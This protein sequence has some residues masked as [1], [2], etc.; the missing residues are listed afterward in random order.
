MSTKRGLPNSQGKN[1]KKFKKKRKL[2]AR[3]IIVQNSDEG[4]YK[5]IVV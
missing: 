4:M 1:D 5:L 2:N 3:E